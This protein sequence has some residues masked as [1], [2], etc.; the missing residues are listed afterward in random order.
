MVT[1]GENTLLIKGELLVKLIFS[2]GSNWGEKLFKEVFG[3]DEFRT[4]VLEEIELYPG[5]KSFNIKTSDEYFENGIVLRVS[6]VNNPV[7]TVENSVSK[8]QIPSK[9]SLPVVIRIFNKRIP[10]SAIDKLGETSELLLSQNKEMDVELLVNG[11]IIGKGV[12][13]KIKDK[14]KLKI[15]ELYL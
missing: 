5:D 11:N 10:L 15:S 12:L 14:Y 2:Q 4:E 9:I 6:R 8:E 3:S 1:D 7:E 13:K